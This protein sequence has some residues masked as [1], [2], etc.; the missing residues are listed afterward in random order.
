[1]SK[2][3]SGCKTQDHRT[4]GECMRAKGVK[5]G[6]DQTNQKRADKTLDRYADLRKYGAQP[7]ST[8]AKDIEFAERY[9][10]KAGTGYQA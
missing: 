10:N 4:L 8:G 6:A 7:K 9:S 3:S 2:C 5:V 1:M